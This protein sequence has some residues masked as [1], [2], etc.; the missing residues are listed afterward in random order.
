MRG[1]P[2]APRRS[3]IATAFSVRRAPDRAGRA[4]AS[5]WSSRGSICSERCS[6][7]SHRFASPASGNG[8]R[9][10][11]CVQAMYRTIVRMSIRV[12]VPTR[13]AV[14]PDSRQAIFD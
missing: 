11:V 13:V 2:F 3:Q 9:I 10:Y 6:S 4:R 14:V 1:K 8:G 7:A 5:L 12:A